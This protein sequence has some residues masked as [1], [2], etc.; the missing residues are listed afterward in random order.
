MVSSIGVDLQYIYIYDVQDS[1]VS[2]CVLILEKCFMNHIV[3]AA[4][5]I[6]REDIT[7]KKVIWLNQDSIS[8]GN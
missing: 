5:T 3:K 7:A 1:I 6:L 4:V 8:A 2:V